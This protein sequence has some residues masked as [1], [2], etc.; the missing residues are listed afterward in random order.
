MDPTR[1]MAIPSFPD[2]YEDAVE[3]TIPTGLHDPAE[4]FVEDLS[5][6]RALDQLVPPGWTLRP[7]IPA[8]LLQTR[9]SLISSTT[10]WD[11]LVELTAKLEE[12][13]RDSL[14]LHVFE[15]QR[16]VVLEKP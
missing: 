15:D 12:Q 14:A 1:S 16:L 5:L 4:I 7:E 6:Q 8:R 9:I 3:L 11:A 13:T 2:F 10:W